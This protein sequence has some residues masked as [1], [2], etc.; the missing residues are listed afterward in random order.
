MTK[1]FT[2]MVIIFT[3][4]Q[5]EVEFTLLSADK[6]WPLFCYF[7]LLYFKVTFNGSLP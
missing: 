4:A 6:T 7:L 5:G 1:I 3:K 2:L